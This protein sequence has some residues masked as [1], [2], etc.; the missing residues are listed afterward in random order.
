[1]IARGF[2]LFFLFDCLYAMGQCPSV[3]FSLPASACLNGNVNI[4]NTSS[5]GV[6]D[7][8]YCSGDLNNTPT[9]QSFYALPNAKGQ[10]GI[11]LIKDGTMWYGFATGTYSNTLYQMEF[12]NGINSA[13]TLVQN[14]GS[15]GIITQ[16]GA[17]RIIKN[18]GN[19]F[20]FI[21]STTNGDL[22]KLSFGNSLA[23]APTAAVLTSTAGYT[24]SG[25]ALGH[26]AT[27]GWVCVVTTSANKFEILRL[28]NNLSAPTP[29]DTLTT[30]VAP[31]ANN[32]GDVDLVQMCDQWFAIADNI[33]NGVT[34]KLSFGTKLFQQPVI[35]QLT[36]LGAGSGRLRAMKE[37]ENYFLGVLSN[38]LFFKI[39]MGNDLNNITPVIT[40]E[41]NFGLIQGSYAMAV[42]KENSV[43][44]ISVVDFSTGQVNAIQYPNVCSVNVVS[45]NLTTPVI[46]YSQSG[47]YHVALTITNAS[48]FSSTLTKSISVSSS[49]APDI[50]FT[51]QNVCAGSNVNFTSQNTSGNISSYAWDFGD[52]GV[53][54]SNNPSYAFASASTYT[55]TLTVTAS[56]SCQNTVQKIVQIFNPPQASFSLPAAAPVCTN[57]NY[58]FANTSTF[59]AGSNPVWQWSVNGTNISNNQNLNFT[60]PA[61]AAQSIMLTA[62]IPGCTTQATQSIPSVQQGPSVNFNSPANGCM[63]SSVS[64]TNTTSGTTTGYSWAFGDGNTSTQP[65][66]SN[67]FSTNGQYAVVLTTSNAA[68]CQ[69]SFSKNFSVYTNPQ[70]D[71]VIEAPPFSCA[72]YPAQF[73]NNTP[74]LI[75]SNVATWA[76]GFGDSANGTSNQKNPAYTYLTATNFNV[77]LLAT[78]NFGCSKSIQKSIAI[79]PSPKAIF[80]NLP[81][82]VN[83]NT[84]FTDASA[85]SISTYQWLIQSSVL[86][87]Q[88]PIYKFISSGS[89]PVT[90]AVTGSNGCK[91]QT[92]KSIVVPILPVMDFTVTAPCTAHPTTFQES[93]PGGVDPSVAWNWNFGP[94]SDTGSPVRY[95]FPD[96]GG[97]SVTMSATRKSGCVYSVSK[98]IMISAS[99]VSSFTPSVQAG[100]APLDVVFINNSVANFYQWQFGDANHSTSNASSP[101]FIYTT[102][103]DYKVLLTASNLLGCSDTV[104]TIINVVVP[105][106]DLAMKNFSLTNDP[107]SNS[108][109][110]T[111]TIFNLGNIPL[112]N[113]EVEIDLAGNALLKEKI[114]AVVQPGK[115]VVQTLSLQIVPESLSYICAV[116]TTANDAE[117]DNNK[118]CLSLTHDDVVMPPYPNPAAGSLNFD[119]ISIENE[120]VRVIVY[121]SNGEVA[122]EQSL[123]VAAGLGQLTLNTSTFAGG[124]YLIQ[125][126]GS[127]TQKVFRFV[128]SY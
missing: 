74:A 19:W 8:D 49:T 67:T 48:G 56:N 31:N 112:T 121:K 6:I 124:L 116:V 28:G 46:T 47:T 24:Y 70:P 50:D 101:V 126:T 10:P 57:Q 102:L 5:A 73:D 7:W 109:K 115:S 15:L 37:G 4:K 72:N 111:V 59:D 51:S 88:N 18:N 33:G 63:G 128:V 62:S 92:T 52:G 44:N 69:N 66:P 3:S 79:L 17:I 108:S 83:Q 104:S 122:F 26:D 35:T 22:Y 12:G 97:Y 80:T 89:F 23:N 113:P 42:A 40:N 30:A 32:L 127:K 9:A 76:W 103:G 68:G 78:T 86:S 123:S 29:S 117:V 41:G 114:L 61:A 43:W 98:N 94:A 118:Q 34:Y 105:H 16:P 55:T 64:F 65:S 96:V 53:S 71:F 82:C 106:I 1:M 13:P 77:S 90:L 93:N 91:N 110:A 75:D 125:F 2:F 39:G 11:E 38:G 85:G 45:P 25:L 21:L 95:L 107:T 81:A 119:W 87:N 20:G 60:I 100:A 99:P 36:D 58:L 54:S 27:N 120:N 84:Q 14:L